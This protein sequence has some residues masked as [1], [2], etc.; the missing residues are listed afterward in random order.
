METT[1]VFVNGRACV[2][3]AIP[4]EARAA[5]ADHYFGEAHRPLEDGDVVWLT[6]QIALD[7]RYHE[8]KFAWTKITAVKALFD[9][10][11]ERSKSGND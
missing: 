3:Y 11:A 8:G 2:Y 4:P 7:Q 9:E 5:A 1:V 6:G 10:A